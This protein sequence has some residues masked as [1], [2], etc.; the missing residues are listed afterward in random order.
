M[1]LKKKD[2]EHI[3]KYHF[4]DFAVLDILNLFLYFSMAL[5]LMSFMR[6]IQKLGQLELL[7]GQALYDSRAFAAFYITWNF[8]F[9]RFL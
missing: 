1:E 9:G 5:K 8:L 4:D 7:I 6:F 2:F 3:L